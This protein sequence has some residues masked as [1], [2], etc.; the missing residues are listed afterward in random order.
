MP[1]SKYISALDIGT[2]KVCCVVGELSKRQEVVH[3]RHRLCQADASQKRGNVVEQHGLTAAFG[4][5]L[6]ELCLI[7]GEQEAR[8]RG[9]QHVR[10]HG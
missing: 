4:I 10:G 6:G 9:A 8:A 1:R 3:E 2:T 5:G 7:V